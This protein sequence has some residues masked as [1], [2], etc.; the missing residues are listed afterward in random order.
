MP[1]LEGPQC[2]LGAVLGTWARR[3]QGC[4]AFSHI[5][6][7]APTFSAAGEHSLA[8]NFELLGF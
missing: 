7:T 2:H 8:L 5:L 6:E 3:D 4:E 1:P